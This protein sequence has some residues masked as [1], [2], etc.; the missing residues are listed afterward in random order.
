MRQTMTHLHYLRILP[1]LLP[2]HALARHVIDWRKRCQVRRFLDLP[3]HF[4]LLTVVWFLGH[5]VFL[6][7]KLIQIVFIPCTNDVKLVV[8]ILLPVCLVQVDLVRQVRRHL[9]KLL[10]RLDGLSLLLLV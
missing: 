5:L 2:V 4:L 10:V 3:G 1:P 8:P 9:R 6:P 7:L